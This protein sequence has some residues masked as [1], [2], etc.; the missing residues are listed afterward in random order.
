[1]AK[2]PVYNNNLAYGKTA[3]VRT[4]LEEYVHEGTVAIKMMQDY[5]SVLCIDSDYNLDSLAIGTP[6]VTPLDFMVPSSELIV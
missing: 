4:K 6:Q 3:Y 1:M 2:S 5:E